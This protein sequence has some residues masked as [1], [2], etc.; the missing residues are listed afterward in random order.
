ME[1]LNECLN[2][3]LTNIGYAH[4]CAAWVQDHCK[5]D[6][7]EVALRLGHAL[8]QADADLSRFITDGASSAKDDGRD[9]A[10]MQINAIEK[11]IDKR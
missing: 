8:V 3:V 2:N 11:G 1:V 7:R 10:L 4:A 6:C 9:E 5:G